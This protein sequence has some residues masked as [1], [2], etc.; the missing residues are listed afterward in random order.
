MSNNPAL[1]EPAPAPRAV[2]AERRASVRHV[3]DQE[4]L[5]RPLEMPDSISWGAKVHDISRGGLGLLI[6]YPFRPGT[7]LAIDLRTGEAP[8]R[9]LLV[10]VVYAKDQADGSWFV[11]CEFIAP[12]TDTELDSLT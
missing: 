6:C 12:L 7:F 8:S 4:V 10:R 3:C 1:A 11:G 5:S 9:T 2:L